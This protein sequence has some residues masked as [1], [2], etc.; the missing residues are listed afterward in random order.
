MQGAW[1]AGDWSK[2]AQIQDRLMPLH[3]ALF[4]ETNPAPVKFAASLLGKCAAD[5]RLPLASLSEA[6]RV[7]V[8]KAMATAGLIN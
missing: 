5:V 4:C 7:M 6:G 1:R 2:A 8:H 3:G